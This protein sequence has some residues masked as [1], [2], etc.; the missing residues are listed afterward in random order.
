MSKGVRQLVERAM[1][2]AEWEDAGQ[3]WWGRKGEL[4]LKG[5]SRQRTVVVL[6]RRLSNTVGVT[7]PTLEGQG[8]LFW[9]EARGPEMWE[10]AVLVTSLDLEVRSLAQLYRDRADSENTFD[11]LKN[12]WGWAGFT[13]RDVARCQIMAQLT[14]LVYDWWTLFVRLA[15]PDRHRE[16]LTSR[17][18]L[19]HSVARQTRHA[20]QTRLTVTACHGRRDWVIQALVR[21]SQFFRELRETAE[22]LTATDRWMRILSRALVKYLHGR[23]LRPP[24]R[25]ATV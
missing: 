7:L 20:G 5:W 18:L 25:L 24:P 3:G 10:F 12:Q 2:A 1:G 4:R 23:Q 17:P 6:R 13:T 9:V 22:Q 15:D 11:E 14:A 21:I 8:E 16:A 19:L